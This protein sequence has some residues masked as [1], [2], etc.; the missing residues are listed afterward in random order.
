MK[1]R[2]IMFAFATLLFSSLAFADNPTD[3]PLLPNDGYA[4]LLHPENTQPESQAKPKRKRS[5]K[6]DEAASSKAG[7][8]N[9]PKD[10]SQKQ[11]SDSAYPASSD[12]WAGNK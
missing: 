12:G 7:N 1:T 2:A 3:A 9:S 10:K 5:K 11:P 4:V 6:N 8:E